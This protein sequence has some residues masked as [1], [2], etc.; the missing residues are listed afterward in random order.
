MWNLLDEFFA[1]F[2]MWKTEKETEALYE[3]TPV[4][5]QCSACGQAIDVDDFDSMLTGCPNC[6]VI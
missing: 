6:G 3:E 4:G 2:T 5:F 1:V